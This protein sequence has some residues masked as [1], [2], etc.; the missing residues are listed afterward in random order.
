MNK[1][2]IAVLLVLMLALSMLLTGCAYDE[3]TED[4][5]GPIAEWYFDRDFEGADFTYERNEDK[6]INSKDAYIV[7]GTSE[8]GSTF[9]I[10]ILKDGSAVYEYGIASGKAQRIGTTTVVD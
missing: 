10:G 3:V 1:K 8:T 2:V 9:T 7:T 5:I 6:I 4:E